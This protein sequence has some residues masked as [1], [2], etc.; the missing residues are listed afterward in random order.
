MKIEKIK[1]LSLTGSQKEV[2]RHL[3]ES[4]DHQQWFTSSM[5]NMAEE[6]RVSVMTVKRSIRIFK[7]KIYVTVKNNLNEHGQDAENSYK[8][9]PYNIKIDIERMPKTGKFL[10]YDTR[11]G[12]QG[13]SGQIYKSAADAERSGDL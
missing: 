4:C 12:Y 13:S 3:V 9:W 2:L 8:L 7:D 10:P 1:N 5:S 11:Y 6:C